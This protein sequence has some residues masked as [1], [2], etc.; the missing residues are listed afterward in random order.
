MF[1]R[2]SRNIITWTLAAAAIGERWISIF[3][4]E[5]SFHMGGSALW[6]LLFAYITWS[7]LR[8]VKMGHVVIGS[9]E[10]TR[11]S[12]GLVDAIEALAQELHPEAFAPK[13][14]NN[15]MKMENGARFYAA[16]AAAAS[17]GGCGTC[18]R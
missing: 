2:C 10:F 4:P 13:A 5:H 1:I 3:V 14:E 15:K 17:W 8:A 6:L 7:E 12:P 18:A 11:P 16:T 9:D